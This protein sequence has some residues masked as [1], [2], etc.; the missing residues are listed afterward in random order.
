LS[1]EIRI[2]KGFLE[3]KSIKILKG[4]RYRPTMEQGRISLFN[5]LGEKISNSYFLDLFA[6]SGIVGLEALSLGA[7]MV[8]F[9]ENYLPAVKILRANVKSLGVEEKAEVF[10]SD[11]FSFLNKSPKEKFD[12]IFMDPPYSLGEKV[13]NLLELIEKNSWLK[14]DGILIIEHHKKAKIIQELKN[15][16]LFQVKNFGETIFSYYKLR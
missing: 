10:L 8:V 16:K 14:E 1:S 2:S 3:G 15:L 6:G 4:K 11:V 5:S 13:N 7:R 9:V 12:I